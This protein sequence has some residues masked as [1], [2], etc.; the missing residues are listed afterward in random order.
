[1]EMRLVK[2]ASSNIT[3]KG[4]TCRSSAKNNNKRRS[5]FKVFYKHGS[6]EGNFVRV[7]LYVNGSARDNNSQCRFQ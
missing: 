7:D 1:M 3:P 4:F 5:Q 2:G 6:S